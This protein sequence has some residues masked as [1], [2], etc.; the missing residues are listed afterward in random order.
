[1]YLV[2]GTCTIE[3]C[4]RLVVHGAIDDLIRFTHYSVQEFLQINEYLGLLSV[5]DLTKI[6][7]PYLTFNVFENGPRD[8]QGESYNPEIVYAFSNHAATVWD[9]YS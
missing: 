5:V 8:G 9:Q 7:L 6:C 1:M 2:K 3:I 4:E